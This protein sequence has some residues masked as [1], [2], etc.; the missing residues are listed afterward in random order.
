MNCLRSLE[1]QVVDVP[2]EVIV[3]DSAA[4]EAV[5]GAVAAFPAVRLVRSTDGLNPGEARNLGARHARGGYLAFIDADCHAAEHWLQAAL[6]GLRNGARLIGGPVLDARPLHPVASMDNLMQFADFAPRRPDGPAP[7]FPGC[8]FALS[9]ATFD[10]LGGFPV[11]LAVSGDTLITAAAAGRWPD[12]VLFSRRVRILHE[13]RRG[14]AELWRH[15]EQFG[16]Q[17]GRLGL[18]LTAFQRR[19]GHHAVF[20]ALFAGRRLVYF[21]LRVVQWNPTKLPQLIVFSPA[22]LIGL[23]GWAR[24][25]RRGC[26]E[27]SSRSG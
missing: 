18:R 22:L 19:W 20:A 4:D 21:L 14:I 10:E 23:A 5:A 26:R 17:R 1:R 8:N 11:A 15:H 27:G 13:G 25:F 12:R 16:Y 7:H 6:D 24:G 2:F 3:V 9:R